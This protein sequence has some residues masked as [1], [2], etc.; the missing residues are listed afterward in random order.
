MFF[1]L[2]YHLRRCQ[3][4]GAFR[5]RSSSGI[6]TWRSARMPSRA[7]SSPPPCFSFYSITC[8]GVSCPAPFACAPRQASLPG[9]ARACHHEQLRPH[10]HVFLF[11]LSPAEVSAVRRLS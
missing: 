5:L 8:G 9:E 11:T 7:T 3:L 6:A 2:L 4:S 1:F 10:P